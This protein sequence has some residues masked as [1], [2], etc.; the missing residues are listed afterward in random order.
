MSERF[1]QHKRDYKY[2]RKTTSCILFA[3]YGVE[4]C[5][6]ILIS[7]QQIEKTDAL[8]EERRLIEECQMAINKR[9][10][11]IDEEEVREYKREYA[12]EYYQ[13]HK[14][15]REKH[16]VKIDVVE[17]KIYKPIVVKRVPMTSIA[18]YLRTARPSLSEGSLK[19]YTSIITSLGKQMKK[20]YGTPASVIA[21]FKEILEHLRGVVPKNRKTRLASLVVFISATEG[22]EEA[23]EAFRETMM[24]DKVLATEELK[25]QQLSDRQKEGW[26]SWEEVLHR[27]S[28]LE[29]D[30][31]RLW[32]KPSLDKSEFHRLQ[33]YVL[34][35]CLVLLDGPRR[36]L[37]WVAFKLKS[38]D[39]DKDNH[40]TY[41]KRKPVLVFHQYKTA[42]VYGSQT[43]DAPMLGPILK[44]WNEMNPHDHLL[45][46]YHQSGPMTQSQ[47]TAT[48]HDFFGKPI[49]TSLLRHI[50]LTH[51]HKNTPALLEMEKVAEVMG[52]SVVQSLEYV[53][54]PVVDATPV[55]SPKRKR[56]AV[57]QVKP[58]RITTVVY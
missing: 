18:D 53:K 11:F 24:G 52:H 12:H 25:E 19:T 13:R 32:K 34:L 16:P 54:K 46:N 36:S 6:V 40:L 31:K 50:W 4:T 7:E 3:K 37:D 58:M 9:R 8:R 1:S 17:L 55:P 21:D 42:G 49:S 27:Y 45:M 10:P 15:Y 43:V 35:S 44:K 57:A 23:I 38:V 22:N 33:H 48:L 5:S 20:D 30:V 14:E 41:I 28:E 2:G 29:K 47:L 39:K 56:P 26:I 51:F